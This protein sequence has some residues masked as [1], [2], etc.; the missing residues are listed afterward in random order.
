MSKHPLYFT[1][2]GHFY[3]PPRE[4]PW[5][6]V[7]E[8]QPSAKP[9][10]DWNDRIASECYSPNSASRILS[11]TGRIQ[12]I[13]NNYDFMSF[14][15]GPTL[16]GWIRTHVPDTY[17][18]IQEADKRSMER[19]NGHGNA[20]AQVYNHI[21]MPLA[22]KEDK[23]TQ[24]RWGIE[25]FKF[26]FGR[27]PEAM[28]L[29]ET[30]INLDTVV[31]LIQAGIK[32][33]ILSPTQADSF[34]ALGENGL[35]KEG[36]W[37]GCSNTDIDTTRP[38]RI[39]P[40]DK[41]GNLV[42]D[43]YLD[44]FFYNPWLSSA[45]GFEHLLR[46]AGTFG[47]RIADAW[48]PNREE[49]QLVSIGTDGESYG[50]HEPFGDM[51]AAW[52]Y[53]RYAPENNM[54]PVNYGWFLE[55]FPPAHEVLLKNFHSEGCAWSCA[56]GVGR[57]YRDCGCSTGGGP[58]W[59]QKW[60]GPLREAFNLLK[61]L[62]D[63]IFVREFEKVSAVNPWEARNQY[64]Q[65]LVA[66][67][68]ENPRKHFLDSI[69][70]R[71]QNQ[72][73][74]AKATRLLEIQKFCLFSYTS[75]GWFFNDIE[76]LEPVQNMRYALRAMELM[77]PFLPM[78]HNIKSQFL[79]TLAAAT[80]N[81][82]KMNGAQV[83]SE[84]AEECIPVAMKLMAERA[85]IFHLGLEDGYDESYDKRFT[86]SKISSRRRQTLVRSTFDD[87]SINEHL[88]STILVITDSLGRIN[89]VVA[90]GEASQSGL[91]FVENPNISTE[92]LRHLYPSA[93]VVRMSNLMSDS[94]Q[95][96]NKISTRMHLSALTK[97]FSNFALDH[98]ISIDSLADP[99]HT[100]PDTMRKIL[101]LEI[102]SRLH[103]QTLKYLEEPS[104]ELYIEIEGLVR[105]A[106]F[107]QTNFSF[108]G[109]GRMFHK[110][111]VA[112]I[113]QV[114]DKPDQNAISHITSLITI[115]DW[116]KLFIDKTSLEN[117]VF[118]VYRQWTQDPQGPLCDLKKMFMWLNF[119]VESL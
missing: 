105:E 53:N 106:T 84:F 118:P 39:F 13:V 9:F 61:N 77:Q 62:A 76:G 116:L 29:A 70:L 112:L 5:T 66:P 65:T 3:Q 26:H 47:R 2:H 55:K 100:L 17:R 22:S 16:M 36:H 58:D 110:K 49:A 109:T 63:D 60:R 51:C 69:L 72:D 44:V 103:H 25:D 32:F 1:I 33:T 79:S 99:D 38:Y 117:K 19:L 21:I 48:D 90:Q 75:C 30:A 86:S 50:H 114:T 80:S 23:K 57:W 115:A 107:L 15:M 87:N 10:H 88:V 12:D 119:E 94:L 41:D 43:G 14:N 42:C 18:R 27:M 59:N 71:P 93:Y 113:Q 54:V 101:S 4:N 37:L 56:H 96:I 35:A 104:Q 45:V 68:Q 83:F 64:I 67:E 8:N 82:H 11:P 20:I 7:I 6:G 91:T 92:A 24:I 102:N 81:E 78:G 74:A 52:L 31:E 34:R 73:E 97:A 28:W 98:G 108:G 111:L 40:R 95:R 89:L 46:D 85:A